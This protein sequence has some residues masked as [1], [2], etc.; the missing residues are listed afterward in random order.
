MFGISYVAVDFLGVG[1]AARMPEKKNGEKNYESS[2]I[3]D[4]FIGLDELRPTYCRRVIM[5]CT[6]FGFHQFR[7]F[8]L[9]KGP[10]SPFPYFT[11]IIRNIASSST[12]PTSYAVY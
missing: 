2:E 9:M 12:A 8:H 6:I 5:I 11:S 7:G 3:H 1:S 4:P 10:K